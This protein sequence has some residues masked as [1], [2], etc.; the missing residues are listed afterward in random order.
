[1]TSAHGV[2]PPC[3]QAECCQATVAANVLANAQVHAR[4][5]PPPSTRHV[6]C[7]TLHRPEQRCDADVRVPAQ[8]NFT[9]PSTSTSVDINHYWQRSK[10][11]AGPSQKGKAS[12]APKYKHEDVYHTTGNERDIDNMPYCDCAPPTPPPCPATAHGSPRQKSRRSSPLTG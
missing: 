10:Y 11:L 2:G 12:K 3:L 1:M 5:A 6:R 9:A 8:F 7:T 4:G